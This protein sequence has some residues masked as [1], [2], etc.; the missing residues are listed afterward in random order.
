MHDYI[1]SHQPAKK[2]KRDEMS[3]SDDEN[4]AVYRRLTPEEIN[5]QAQE[6]R[7]AK[8]SATRDEETER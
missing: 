5:Q 4:I 8:E 3:D 6:H 7:E 2:K 1:K